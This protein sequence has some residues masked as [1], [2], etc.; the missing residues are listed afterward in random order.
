MNN[1]PSL[2]KPLRISINGFGRIGRCVLRAMAETPEFKDGLLQITT[3]NDLTDTAMLAH[4]LKYDSVHG[5]FNGEVQVD[6]KQIIVN[7]KK[8]NISAIPDPAKLPWAAEKVDL[9]LECTGRFKDRAETAKHLAAGA[10]KVLFSA[11]L[12]DADITVVYGINHQNFDPAKHEIVSNASCTTNCLAPVAKVIDEKFKII[13]G[14][15]TTIHSYTNDQRILDLPHSDF[16]RARAAALSMIPTTTGA[17]KAVGLVLPHLKGKIDG[18][19]IRVPT[20]NVS[21]VDFSVEVQTATTKE[22]VNAVLKS[23]AQGE[24]KGILKVTD[25]ELVSC[26]FNGTSESSTVDGA[27]TAVID[28]TYIKVLSWYDNEMGFSN[29]MVDMT[30]FMGSKI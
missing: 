14:S 25:E 21:L 2:K 8:I 12:K 1:R 19:S 16:R 26:D 7:G 15:M 22:D 23:A 28:K 24:L 10:K 4:L 5:A 13:H 27:S 30:Y 29:R 9:V 18:I 3:I 11:P 17:A 6:G 20:P